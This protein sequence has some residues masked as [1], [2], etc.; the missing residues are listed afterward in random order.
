[1][2]GLDTSEFPK[3]EGRMPAILIVEDDLLLRLALSDYLQEY[4]FKTFEASNVG[5]AVNIVRQS[6]SDID[7]V[8]SDINSSRKMDGIGLAKWIHQNH[9]DIPIWFAS[10]EMKKSQVDE[11]ACAND[12]FF[13]KPYDLRSIVS[14]IR[15][16]VIGNRWRH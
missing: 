11:E 1:M 3:S 2:A 14:E 10:G 7:L 15:H 16:I 5:D 13:P 12:L 6:A 4:G 8:F 9:P